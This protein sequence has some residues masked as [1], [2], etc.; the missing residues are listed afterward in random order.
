MTPTQPPSIPSVPPS[1]VISLVSDLREEMTGQHARLRTDMS[2]GFDK[3]AD[4]ID[5][6]FDEFTKIQAE[7]RS[8]VDRMEAR[9]EAERN[10]VFVIAT[11]I[12]LLI[13]AIGLWVR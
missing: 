10:F 1:W 9:Q 13:G 7:L 12:S 2:E 5:R 3:V 4:R 6:K 8:R 11:V